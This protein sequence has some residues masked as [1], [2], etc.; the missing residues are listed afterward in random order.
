MLLSYLSAT[1]YLYLLFI[2]YW[3]GSPGRK[4]STLPR[5]LNWELQLVASA[6]LHQSLLLKSCKHL[7]WYCYLL[8]SPCHFTFVCYVLNKPTYSRKYGCHRLF[9]R[10]NSGSTAFLHDSAVGCKEHVLC[11]V[12]WEGQDA[13]RRSP[14]IT[15]GHNCMFLLLLYLLMCCCVS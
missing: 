10:Q 12:S 3:E 2:N 15:P 9:S 14:G 7:I 4:F 8:L 5:T 6:E 11:D 13:S 1:F